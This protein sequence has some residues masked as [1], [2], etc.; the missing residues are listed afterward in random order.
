MSGIFFYEEL[1]VHH[2]GMHASLSKMQTM[3]HSLVRSF[4]GHS[5]EYEA[6]E[7]V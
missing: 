4:Y 2:V 6:I 7:R 5:S 3:S 1:V